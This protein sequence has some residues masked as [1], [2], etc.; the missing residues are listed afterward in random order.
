MVEL[1]ELL[2]QALGTIN[3]NYINKEGIKKCKEIPE[4]LSEKDETARKRYLYF[5]PNDSPLNEKDEEFWFIQFKND[6]IYDEYDLAL[7]LLK[8]YIQ[9]ISSKDKKIFDSYIIEKIKSFKNYKLIDNILF[10]IKDYEEKIIATISYITK[11]QT[12]LP[13][14]FKL[15]T[16]PENIQTYSSI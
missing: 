15:I 9:Y 2:N 11:D 14:N 13:D 1:N 8:G 3:E 4:K 5:Y 10:V 12:F 16:P 6:N 7:D